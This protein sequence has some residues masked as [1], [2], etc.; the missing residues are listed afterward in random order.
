MNHHYQRPP[1][2]SRPPHPPE[3]SEI[4]LAHMRRLDQGIADLKAGGSRVEA[5]V[6]HLEGR[7]AHI[8]GE[9]H[10]DRLAAARQRGEDQLAIERRVGAVGWTIVATFGFGL[11]VAGVRTFVGL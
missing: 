3:L 10:Q 5:Q 2:P 8:E 1:A 11:G 6:R 4:L 9:I 7:V